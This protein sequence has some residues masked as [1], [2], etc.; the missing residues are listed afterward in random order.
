MAKAAETKPKD[1]KGEKTTP[2]KASGKDN[3]YIERLEGTLN[4]MPDLVITLDTGGKVTSLNQAGEQ[5]VGFDADEFIGKPV[6]GTPMF[7]KEALKTVSKALVD[8]PKLGHVSGIEIDLTRK[9]G[10]KVPA[11]FSASLVKDSAGKPVGIVSIAKDVSDLK[12]MMKEQEDSAAYYSNMV[13][14]ISDMILTVDPALKIGDMNPAGEVMTGYSKE[15]F[16]GKPLT[17]LPMFDKEAL[18]IVMKVI[19][20]IQKK[21]RVTDLEIE[22]TDKNGKKIPVLCSVTMMKDTDGKSAGMVVVGKDVTDI[23]KMMKEQEDSAAYYSGMISNMSDM[24]LTMDP[25]MKLTDTNPACEGILG[26]SKEELVGKPINSLPFFS[27]EALKAV[28][29]I[30]PELQ[31]KGIITDLDIELTNKKGEVV[32][33]LFSAAQMKNADGKPMG[34]VISGKD[35]TDIKNMMEAQEE[36][37]KYLE[38][39]VKNMLEVT[40]AAAAGDLTKKVE[41]QRDDEVGALAEGLNDMIR[42][43]DT[44]MKEQEEAAKYLEKNVKNMLEVVTAAAA[45]DLSKKAKKERDDEVGE[46]ADGINYMIQNI[47]KVMQEQEEA[48]TYLNENVKSML[49]VTTAAAAGDL[50]KMVEKQRDDEVGALAEG[51][52]DMIRNI[53]TMMNDQQEQRLYLEENAAQIGAALQAAAAGDLSI[54]LAKTKDDGI[55]SLIDAYNDTMERLSGI[56]TSNL[57]VAKR[58]LDSANNLAGTSEEMNAGMEQLATG[59]SQVAEGSQRLA[60]IVQGTARDIDDASNVLEDTDRSVTRSSDEGK[61]AIKVSKEVQGAAR[62]AGVS[63]EKIQGGIKETS[64][65]VGTMSKSID[66][67]SEMGNVITDVA[68]QTNMLALNAA[69]EAAR[70]GEAGKGFAVVADAVKDLAE[71]VKNAARES[72][73]AVDGIKASGTHAI[74]VSSEADHEAEEGGTVLTTALKGVDNTVESLEGIN[75]MLQNINEG[76]KKVVDTFKD[77]TASIEK[78]SNISE[79]NAS[80]A[81]ESSASVEEQTA[82]IEELTAES[83]NLSD[84]AQ[85]MMDELAVFK[86]QQDE[87]GEEEYTEECD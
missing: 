10:G 19:P 28:M 56:I 83:Q 9:D 47:S 42:N 45:G 34:M 36:A 59:A 74:S 86:L 4:S 11:N 7:D 87:E 13:N 8:I 21:G 69:I 64:E 65:S 26:Y 72:I 40:T 82:S 32:P 5:M 62:E 17:S 46:L 48:A 58:V 49:E 50:T 1:D 29:K 27:K 25:G 35:M 81:E 84:L 60:D 76:T 16:V 18:S 15:K 2:D 66:K 57:D 38:K 63:F 61:T 78:V 73:N 70:A 30:I 23:K 55:G 31:K 44:T 14:N 39:N 68:S 77:V 51:L 85:T 20:E 75:M 37:A 12:K 67:V 3:A 71:Q 80:S 6:M 33:V 52:N 41:K 43:I 54:T 79:A 24:I 53:D 22:L